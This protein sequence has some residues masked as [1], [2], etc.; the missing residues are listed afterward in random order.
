MKALFISIFTGC[1]SLAITPATAQDAKTLYTEGVQLKTDRKVKEAAKK[2]EQANAL[3]PNYTE[4]LYELG[5]CYNDLQEYNK[6]IGVLRQA[7]AGWPDVAK[8]HFELGYALQKT[9]QTDSAISSFNRCLSI[10]SGYSLAYKQLGQI[11]YDQLDYTSAIEHFGKY[12]ARASTPPTDY[13]YWYRKGFCYNAIKDYSNAVVALAKSQLIKDDYTNTWLEMGFALSRLKKY[14][15]A[16]G[17]YKEAI[18]LDPKSHIGYN[19]IGE[20]YR[21][22]KKNIDSAMY[23]YQQ[24]LAINPNERKANF[25]MGYCLNNR[26][27]YDEAIVYIQKAI[28]SE[29]D[30][31]AAFVELGYS[32]YMTGMSA[33]ALSYFSKAIKLSPQNENARYYSCLVYIKQKNKPMAQ[34]MV[35]E[36]KAFSSKHVATLQPKVEAM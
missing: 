11:A 28:A 7:R 18:Q 21:D 15:E 25:G 23:W 9:S 19:G 5:W 12:E 22:Y 10:N 1:C 32:Y 8:V 13:L 20:V 4:S 17:N 3:Q 29:P 26:G 34:K 14:D 24:T 36:L 33:D 27:K 30:Y 16:I 31:V 35:D 2:F 6:A